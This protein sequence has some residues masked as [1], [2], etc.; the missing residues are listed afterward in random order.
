M[1]LVTCSSSICNSACFDLTKGG[2]VCSSQGEYSFDRS[3][4]L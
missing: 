2:L 1:H 3:A 4:A